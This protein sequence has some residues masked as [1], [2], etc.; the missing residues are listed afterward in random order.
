LFLAI[1]VA[2]FADPAVVRS[3][4]A[5]AADRIRS[6]KRAPGVAQ[7]FAPGEPEWHRKE[8][9]V[10]QV[11]LTPAVVDMLKRM[12]RQLDVPEALLAPNDVVT[13][14]GSGHAEA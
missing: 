6:G 13:M 7:L 8:L 2:H 1:D 3:A 9:A 14:E 4:A 11:T 10:G 12:A 5:A